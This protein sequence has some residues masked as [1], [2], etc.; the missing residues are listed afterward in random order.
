MAKAQKEQVKLPRGAVDLLKDGLVYPRPVRMYVRTEE[1]IKALDAMVRR[2]PKEG[3]S[4]EDACAL[5]KQYGFS[6]K[7]RLLR[8]GLKMTAP[9]H[10][11]TIY[12]GRVR[13]ST[14]ELR[15][16]DHTAWRARKTA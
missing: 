16:I 5:R 12:R 1:F 6:D 9:I 14:R 3:V 10:S 7:S 15:E 13:L 8:D 2:N 4:I 11:L